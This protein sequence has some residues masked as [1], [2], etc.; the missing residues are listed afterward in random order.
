M[1][2]IN[3]ILKT[4]SSWINKKDLTN[5]SMLKK[6]KITLVEKKHMLD[7]STWSDFLCTGELP[8]WNSVILLKS[9]ILLLTSNFM[10]SWNYISTRCSR[11]IKKVLPQSVFYLFP[12]IFHAVSIS[13]S[14]ILGPSSAQVFDFLFTTTLTTIPWGP[15]DILSALMKLHLY[16]ALHCDISKTRPSYL[17]HLWS[18]PGV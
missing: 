5:V 2:I 9:D 12:L 6:S 1:T 7:S 11:F 10:A 8:N 13:Q 3:F 18:P 15:S 4:V 14:I 17:M 16:S